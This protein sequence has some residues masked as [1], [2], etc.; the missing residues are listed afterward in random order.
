MTKLRWA[1][2]STAR[3][4]QALIPPLRASDRNELVA[5]ASRDLARAQQFQV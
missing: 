3:I 5:V 1:L 2:L 4:N